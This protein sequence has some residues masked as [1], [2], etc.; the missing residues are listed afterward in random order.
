M[1]FDKIRFFDDGGVSL[2]YNNGRVLE[3][4]AVVKGTSMTL[5]VPI[6]PIPYEYWSIEEFDAGYGYVFENLKLD[7]I[8]YVRQIA[9]G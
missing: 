1:R 8:S 4:T 6:G 5:Y 3:G 2:I 7:G 9:G